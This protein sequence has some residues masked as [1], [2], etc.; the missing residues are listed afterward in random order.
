MKRLV[1]A[2]LSVVISGALGIWWFSPTEVLE[3]RTHKLLEILTFDAASGKGARQMGVY[4]FNALLADEVKLTARS[5][6]EANGTFQR[7]E[8]EA[9]YSWLGAQAKQSFFKLEEIDSIEFGGDQATVRFRLEALVELP[10]YRPADRH[11]RVI[12]K[13]VNNDEGW[14]LREAEWDK[15]ER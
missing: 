14:R 5:I 7:S 13:W 1:I 9:A 2:T 3:R 11:F 4:S 15:I 8:L 6:A 10:S 12:F